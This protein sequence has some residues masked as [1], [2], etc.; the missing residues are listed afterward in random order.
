MD[1]IHESSPREIRNS[2]IISK[3]IFFVLFSS[4][5]FALGIFFSIPKS[6]NVDDKIFQII[7]G[8]FVLLIFVLYNILIYYFLVYNRKSKYE[9]VNYKIQYHP[10]YKNGKLAESILLPFLPMVGGSFF[11]FMSFLFGRTDENTL[12]SIFILFFYCSHGSLLN[13]CWNRI[14]YLNSFPVEKLHN[15]RIR[16]IFGYEDYLNNKIIDNEP[17]VYVGQDLRFSTIELPRDEKEKNSVKLFNDNTLDKPALITTINDENLRL[18][19]YN[20]YTLEAK[21]MNFHDFAK[22]EIEF[23]L[24]N[25]NLNFIEIDPDYEIK[26]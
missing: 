2:K 5:L 26:F 19:L 7:I 1:E 10:F 13:V 16:I 25:D 4:S 8:L 9:F 21:I 14:K 12:S 3:T 6:K 17:R 22:L 11:I 18:A 24:R 23:Y 15:H 20:G